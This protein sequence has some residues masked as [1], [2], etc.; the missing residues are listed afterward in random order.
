M[1]AYAEVVPPTA[2]THAVSAP[3]ISAQSQNLIIAKTSLLQVFEVRDVDSATAGGVGN[4]VQDAVNGKYS[5]L[6][7]RL[8]L[9]GEYPIA[10]IITSI[11]DVKIQNS[12]S[13][14]HGLIIAAKDAKFSLIEWDPEA[15]NISTVSIHYY[16]GEELRGSP[17]ALPQSAY[18]GY[19]TVD[20]SYRCAAFKFGQRHLA[21]LPFHG[22]TEQDFDDYDSDIDGPRA[23]P[24]R[25]SSTTDASKP[26]Q[27][28][29]GAS[30]V[31]QLTALDP[32]ILEPIDLA[33]LYEYREPTLGVIYMSRS[34]SI[35]LQTERKDVVTYAAFTLDIEQRARTPLL[36]ISGL[37]SD[38]FKMV[39]L[40]L[41]IGGTLFIGSNEIVHVDQSGKVYAVAVNAFARE[42]SALTMTDQTHL[43]LKLE[44]CTVVGLPSNPTALLVI[45]DSGEL[46]T[47]NF[48]MDGRNIVSISVDRVTQQQGGHIIGAAV[49]S[50]A[51]LSSDSLFL[52]SRN[53]DSTLV[54]CRGAGTR[55]LTRKRSHG[56]MLGMDE[57]GASDEGSDDEDD[58]YGDD[59][60]STSKRSKPSSGG[61]LKDITFSVSDKLENLAALGEPVLARRKRLR[62]SHGSNEYATDSESLQLALPTG[63][64]RSGG[65]AFVSHGIDVE[66]NDTLDISRCEMAWSLA[67]SSDKQNLIVT[68]SANA[69]G[70]TSNIFVIDSLSTNPLEDTDFE[71][72][73]ETLFTGVLSQGKRIIQVTQTEVRS[74][75]NEVKLAQILGMVDE[76]SEAELKVRDASFLDPFVLIVRDDGSAIVLKVDQKGELEELDKSQPF[77]ST[78][79]KSGSLHLWGC[80]GTEASLFMLTEK[81]GLQVSF[82]ST[83]AQN[84]Y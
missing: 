29:Y 68:T 19:L 44:N 32:A 8:I 73:S 74:Y 53:A 22:Q 65:L 31:L 35:S 64:G 6:T 40:A 67:T 54:V 63:C 18:Q 33:F 26:N 58:L 70:G 4:G 11:A 79:W 76:E 47:F 38:I 42:Q 36:S 48:K 9:V 78:Q 10:G 43:G 52:G 62:R 49:S 41:P 72:E 83:P 80:E 17:W 14:G 24:E 27:T 69:S 56:D 28:P 37:P 61:R 71:F 77:T 25:R 60:Y 15:F 34:S 39:P 50:A 55:H 75:D 21:V 7:S 66:T 1:Q 81:G 82:Q 20:P 46:V 13:G 16:E 3:F 23:E 2:V 12:K 57:E 5:D 30:F 84:L 59:A 51:I 45:L